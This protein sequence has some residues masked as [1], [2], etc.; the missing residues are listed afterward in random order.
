MNPWL[1]RLQQAR[2]HSPSAP[3][4]SAGMVRADEIAAVKVWSTVL[5]TRVWVVADDLPREA[6]PTDA[7]VY[8]HAEV[9]ILRQ[10]GREGMVWV[11]AARNLF[12]GRVVEAQRLKRLNKK[13]GHEQR[14]ATPT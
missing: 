6:W 7:P 8:T 5:R 1:E 2:R 11:H 9:Q 10:V 3:A 4:G 12:G 14:P 13:E